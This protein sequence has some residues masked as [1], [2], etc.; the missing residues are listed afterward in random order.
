MAMN[1]VEFNY[2][3]DETKQ[4]QYGLIAEQVETIDHSLIMYNANNSPETIYYQF[5]PPMLLKG[6]QEQQQQIEMLKAQNADQQ[7]ESNETKQII[8]EQ[9]QKIDE[10][11]PQCINK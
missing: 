8:K 5:L 2:K 1:P 10:L 4:K 11:F 9:Q 3:K 7:S 6:W